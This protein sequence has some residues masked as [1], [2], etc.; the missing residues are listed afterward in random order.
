MPSNHYAW[1]QWLLE[2]GLGP[3]HPILDRSANGVIMAG[4]HQKAAYVVNGTL[5]RNLNLS[6]KTIPVYVKYSE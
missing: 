1:R 4:Q 6:K 3:A 5:K 2:T